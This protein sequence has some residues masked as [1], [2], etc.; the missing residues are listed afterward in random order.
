VLTK[1]RNLPVN[2]AQGKDTFAN[3]PTSFGM[4]Y[5]A[6]KTINSLL[7]KQLCL[8]HVEPEWTKDETY[9]SSSR[10]ISSMQEV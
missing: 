5:T 7:P 10:D 8:N 2:L 1:A 4:E 9:T 6:H 3:L